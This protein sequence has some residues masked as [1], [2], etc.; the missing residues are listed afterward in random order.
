[1]TES[2]FISDLH[3]KEEDEQKRTAFLCLCDYLAQSGATRLFILGDFFHYWI[4]IPKVVMDIYAPVLEGLEKLARHGVELHYFVGN[5]DFLFRSLGDCFEHMQIYSEGAVVELG[6]R[7]FYIQHG[8]DL[9]RDDWKYRL[10]KP[11]F[12]S[13]TLEKG[14]GL[15][16]EEKQLGF[17]RWMTREKES[18]DSR[19][20]PSNLHVSLPYCS[21][22]IERYSVEGIVH[23]HV[24]TCSRR[25]IDL[26]S[27]K[28]TLISV[29]PW[30][31]NERPVWKYNEENNVWTCG[32]WQENE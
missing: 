29:G 2:Y 13:A 28:A 7:R 10:T 30:D 27:R 23:G 24:H 31:E 20:V 16:P 14:F 12:Q 15:L 32:K 3:L 25:E 5:H 8:D 1:M 4:N 19:K 11:I 18:E 6:R 21:R 26:E 22:L 17:A 9:C